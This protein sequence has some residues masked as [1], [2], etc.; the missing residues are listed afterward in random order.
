MPVD[1]ISALLYIGV[2]IL[3]TVLALCEHLDRGKHK[4]IWTA[5]I[6]IILTFFCGF[7]GLSVGTDTYGYYQISNLLGEG[8]VEQAGS[9][10]DLGFLYSVRIIMVVFRHPTAVFVIYSLLTN[11]FFILRLRDFRHRIPYY[12]LVAIYTALVYWLL[13][14]G[15]RQMFAVGLIFFAT[16]YLDKSRFI[17]FIAA[18]ITAFL[19]HKTSLLALVYIPINS[20]FSNGAKAKITRIYMPLIAI[21]VATL[22]V[23]LFSAD[24]FIYIQYFNSAYFRELYDIGYMIL[25]RT[26]ILV[27][28]I[29][30]YLVLHRRNEI[31]AVELVIYIVYLALLYLGAGYYHLSRLAWYFIGYE[32]VFWGKILFKPKMNVIEH[33]NAVFVITGMIY[34]VFTIVVFSGYELMPYIPFWL[35]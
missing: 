3:A 9:I 17:F 10:S 8:M 11:L 25:F 7:R 18:V 16:R 6:I 30:R 22:T 1:V 12:Y 20:F 28:T 27:Y 2:P 14:S 32:V 34:S 29:Y 4:I 24:I 5:I 15:I 13:F 35:Y 33:V 31:S 19:F 23:Y 21:I 26:W